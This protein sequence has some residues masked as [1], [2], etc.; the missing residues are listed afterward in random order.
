MKKILS[1]LLPVA[2]LFSLNTVSFASEVATND[3]FPK[4]GTINVEV[5]TRSIATATSPGGAR[6]ATSDD[7]AVSN[8][9]AD[10]PVSSGN[11][12]KTSVSWTYLSGYLV[13]NQ[14][15][16]YN[17]GPAAVQAAMKYLTGST[18][19]QSTIATGCGTTTSGTYL[20]DMLTY[21]N[22]KQEENLYVSQYKADSSSM[23]NYLYSGVVI[24]MAPPIIGMSFSSSDGWL[25]STGGHFMSVYGARSDKSLFALADPWI[26][27]SGSGLSGNSSSYYK[28]AN[29]IYNAYSNKNI[30]LMY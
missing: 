2:M 19:T 20:S 14:T 25:Y 24:Y 6:T 23:E 12:A 28:T 8:Q 22:K 30:G 1:L 11:K 26:G 5:E 27:Y 9:M 17:C 29:V 13:Y 7:I 3:E 21:I 16:S 10:K 18:P 4:A 15:T